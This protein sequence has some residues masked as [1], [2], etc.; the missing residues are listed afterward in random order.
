MMSRAVY[1]GMRIE[2]YPDECAHP[3]PKMQYTPKKEP[4]QPAP[5]K[6]Q[7][8]N[9]FDVLNM[10][11]TEDGDEDGSDEETAEAPSLADFSAPLNHRSPW[12]A[13]VVAV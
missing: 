3:L 11:G 10:D 2:W 8:V 7:P 13:R 6:S 5:K 1:K 4:I 12:N 9:R